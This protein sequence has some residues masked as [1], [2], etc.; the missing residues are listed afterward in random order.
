MTSKRPPL[1]YNSLENVLKSLKKR[2]LWIII[3]SQTE[4][5]SFMGFAG[6]VY[7]IV[8]KE[9]CGTGGSS[10]NV[11]IIPPGGVDKQTKG[12]PRLSVLFFPSVGL[13]RV[14]NCPSFVLL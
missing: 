6:N 1:A 8:L 11:R 10:N 13:C 14:H 12:L 2:E 3:V 9:R 4:R 7:R 5:C